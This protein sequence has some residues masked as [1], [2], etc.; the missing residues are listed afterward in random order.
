MISIRRL[1]AIRDALV[2]LTDNVY[3]YW[4]PKM[5]AP[6]IIWQESSTSGFQADNRKGE[7]AFSGTIDLFSKTEFDPLYDQIEEA[8]S[9]VDGVTFSLSDATYEDE[10][11]LIHHSWEFTIV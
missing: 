5:K 1:E 4:R 2:P 3:H 11:N 6:Y 7:Q 8:L 10:T 9:N